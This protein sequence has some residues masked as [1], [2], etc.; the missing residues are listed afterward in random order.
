MD[1]EIGIEEWERLFLQWGPRFG[2]DKWL[3]LVNGESESEDDAFEV[4]WSFEEIA[5]P[6]RLGQLSVDYSE[7]TH[8]DGASVQVFLL[9]GG[10]AVGLPFATWD[11]EQESFVIPKADFPT[12]MAETRRT[13]SELLDGDQD[14]VD[15]FDGMW[16]RPEGSPIDRDGMEDLVANWKTRSAR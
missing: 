4:R 14:I 10:T 1:L 15:W 6:Y 11:N 7:S 12:I 5:A 3:S 16:E 13:L 9:P 8:G 2:E